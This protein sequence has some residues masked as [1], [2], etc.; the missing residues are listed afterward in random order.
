MKKPQL[1]YLTFQFTNERLLVNNY[2][3]SSGYCK[4]GGVVLMGL[5][6][7]GYEDQFGSI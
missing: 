1:K 4:T 5:I 2:T 6:L 3:S 7:I